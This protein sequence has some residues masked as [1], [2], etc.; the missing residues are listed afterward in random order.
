MTSLNDSSGDLL[1]VEICSILYFAC[2]FL[3][4]LPLALELFSPFPP[5]NVFPIEGKTLIGVHDSYK[6]QTTFVK[7]E[8]S[9]GRAKK[10]SCENY[11]NPKIRPRR[12]L[13]GAKILV[14][15]CTF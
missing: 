2:H 3:N 14:E 7:T 11:D 12:S 6:I 9:G 10:V 8:Q 15:Q 5:I 1:G 13:A 4:V